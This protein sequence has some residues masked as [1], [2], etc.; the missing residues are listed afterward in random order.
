ML[1]KTVG[2][3]EQMSRDEFEMWEGFLE[4]EAQVRER[5]RLAQRAKTNADEA[6]RGMV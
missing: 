1:H 4:W 6:T 2:E 3:I 5:G